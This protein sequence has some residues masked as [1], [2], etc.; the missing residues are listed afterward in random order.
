M[1]YLFKRITNE[2]YLNNLQANARLVE[3]EEFEFM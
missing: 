1:E 3:F 2:Y